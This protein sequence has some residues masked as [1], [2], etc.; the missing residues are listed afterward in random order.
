MTKVLWTPNKT[1]KENSHLNKFNTFLKQK[2]I[3]SSGLNFE[4]LWKW[5]I[6][7]NEL[8]WSQAWNFM[9]ISGKKGKII[10]KKNSIFYKNKFFPDSKLNYAKNLLSKKDNSTAIHFCLN[11]AQR[12]I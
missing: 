4:K 1:L 6:S 5:S 3:F 7:N 9:K 11:V 8:F 10:K 2:K 12:K